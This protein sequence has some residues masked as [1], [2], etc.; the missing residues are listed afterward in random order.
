MKKSRQFP[1]ITKPNKPLLILSAH[2]MQRIKERWKTL[3]TGYNTIGIRQYISNR[4]PHEDG[5][6]DYK[7]F[8]IV[9]KDKTIV[10]LYF[11]GQK[12]D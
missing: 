4:I 6:H 9:V 12:E 2:A 11:R 10:T 1:D 3:Y 8:K 7:G 5:R